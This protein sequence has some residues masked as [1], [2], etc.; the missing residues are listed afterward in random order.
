M[1]R[2]V[3]ERLSAR[4]KPTG[5]ARASSFLL[6]GLVYCGYCGNRMIGVSRHQSW[7]RRRD[8]QQTRAQYRYYQC[9]SRTNQ[10]ICGYHTHRAEEL[11]AEVIAELRA[12]G[13]LR[14]SGQSGPPEREKAAE[15]ALLGSKLK[16]LER[17]LRHHL[18]QAASGAISLQQ[19]R[20]LHQEMDAERRHLEQRLALL[21]ARAQEEASLKRERQHL[22]GA[23]N[24]LRNSWETLSHKDRRELLKMVTDRIT[25]YDDRIEVALRF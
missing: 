1:F 24:R 13:D 11:E 21:D 5:F 16:A 7:T 2:Q 4:P 12:L 14:A 8:G 15:R 9:Q 22:E 25:V 23:L 18:D 17:R 10:S 20:S 6:S 19:L 3:Q